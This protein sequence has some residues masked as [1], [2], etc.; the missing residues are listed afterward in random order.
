MDEPQR[1]Q[2][3]IP[4]RGGATRPS[5]RVNKSA[6]PALERR[7]RVVAFLRA[8]DLD[9]RADALAELEE[10][11]FELIRVI[12]QEGSASNTEPGVRYSAISALAEHVPVANLNLLSDLATFGEDFYVRGHAV[13]A[14]GASG[15]DMAVPLI[16][17]HLVAE[18]RFEQLAARRAIGLLAR[19][20]S[21]DVVRAY[22]STLEG[23]VQRA[24]QQVLDSPE[25]PSKSGSTRRRPTREVTEH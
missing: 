17:R 22:A 2:P 20:E 14:L 11:D 6:L 7:E 12:A 5:V 24:F 10:A 13:L 9:S 16:A 8:H 3:P 21:K 1:N 4:V 18:E 23:E 15:L 19:D 25:A